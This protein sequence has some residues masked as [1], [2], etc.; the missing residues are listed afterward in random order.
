MRRIGHYSV[1]FPDKVKLERLRADPRDITY[2]AFGSIHHEAQL[3]PT[4]RSEKLQSPGQLQLR[5]CA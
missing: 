5:A 1:E 3:A 4:V 2:P